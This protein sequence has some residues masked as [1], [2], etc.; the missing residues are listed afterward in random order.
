MAKSSNFPIADDED[1]ETIKNGIDLTPVENVY[2]MIALH[3]QHVH[4][5]VDQQSS[6][7]VRRHNHR[8]LD[9]RSAQQVNTIELNV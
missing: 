9:A 1:N 5:I 8:I 3:S 7:F 2:K 4:N 6:L